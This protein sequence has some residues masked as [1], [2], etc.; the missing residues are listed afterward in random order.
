M[1]IDNATWHARVGIFYAAKLLHKSKPK[2]E[3]ANVLYSLL[4][5]W[6]ILVTIYRNTMSN[7]FGNNMIKIKYFL[8]LRIKLPKKAKVIIFS[9]LCILNLLFQCGDTEKNPGPKYSSLKFCHWN[10][11][12]LRAHNSV[13]KSLLQ[14]YL[15][16]HN[17]DIACISETFLNSTI[18]DDDE[19][20]K[21][22]GYTMI[23]SDHPSD[24][25]RGGVCIYYKEHIPL[26]KCDDLRTLDN[27]LVTEIRSQ[28]KNVFSHASTDLKVK[29]RMNLKTFA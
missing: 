3:N 24:S 28:N 26:I 6:Y 9:F 11:N 16:Q 29:V 15:I 27:C 4:F 7:V 25:K 18:Q 23:R 2:S 13:K 22:D 8:S 14:A 1:P 17:Y 20:I 21:I 5:F 10:L 19:S 12:G